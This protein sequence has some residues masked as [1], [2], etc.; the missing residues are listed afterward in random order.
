[1]TDID[2]RNWGQQE[3]VKEPK[4]RYA[5][6]LK[7][8]SITFV[9]VTL[10]IIFT[11]LNTGKYP[12]KLVFFVIGQFFIYRYVMK[13]VSESSEK[14]KTFCIKFK[15][16]LPILYILYFLFLFYIGQPYL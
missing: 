3:P 9:S 14:F 15:I 13:N 16:K 5:Q 1:M 11:E 7:I 2:E 12:L 4:D 8:V 6:F 10:T